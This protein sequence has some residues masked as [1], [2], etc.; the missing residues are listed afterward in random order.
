MRLRALQWHVRRWL[1]AARAADPVADAVASMLARDVTTTVPAMAD[2][3]GL[4]QRQLHR[5]CVGAFG[6]GPSTLRRILRL[7]RFLR[8]ARHPGAPRDLA[9][10]A[11]SPPAMRT[12]RT[13]PVTAGASLGP[14]RAR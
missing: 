7:Q 2:A 6:Y 8:L 3:I 5:R 9:G 1:V 13:W 11:L 4:S 10:L 12:S 14:L